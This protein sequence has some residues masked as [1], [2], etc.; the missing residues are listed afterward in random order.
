MFKD[1]VIAQ[2]DSVCLAPITYK[3]LIEPKFYK[4]TS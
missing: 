2:G 1:N 4:Q 3:C